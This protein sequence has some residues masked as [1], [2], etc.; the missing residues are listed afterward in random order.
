MVFL[1]WRR[2]RRPLPSLSP[3]PRL[4]LAG[5]LPGPDRGGGRG[6]PGAAH[7]PASYGGG[8]GPY[9]RWVLRRPNS[10]ALARPSARALRIRRVAMPIG[11]VRPGHREAAGG[12]CKRALER[13]VLLKG[14]LQP[15]TR[16]TRPRGST[17]AGR[18]RIDALGRAAS[19]G[20]RRRLDRERGGPGRG[21]AAAGA[22]GRAAGD[23][24]PDQGGTGRP[25]RGGCKRALERT[26][27]SKAACSPPRAVQGSRPFSNGL[28]PRS[29]AT[30]ARISSKAAAPAESRGK[31]AD[32]RCIH[33]RFPVRNQVLH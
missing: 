11:K 8:R 4:G 1:R 7:P 20:R 30:R 9:H 28:A 2:W 21:R 32:W 19:S 15:P 12:G 13:T 25:P 17:T 22:T 27:F 31:A 16:P 33:S 23:D 3:T 10:G 18:D 24:P 29:A 26:F 6:R 5:G 14:G